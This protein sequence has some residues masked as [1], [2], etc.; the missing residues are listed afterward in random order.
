MRTSLCVLSKPQEFVT[1]DQ[2][3]V[4]S[5]SNRAPQKLDTF[6]TPCMFVN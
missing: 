4:G 6:P 3:H 5:V 2:A 1:D